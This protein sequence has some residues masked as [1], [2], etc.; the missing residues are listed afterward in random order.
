MNNNTQR[1][2]LTALFAA[3]TCVATLVIR[4]PTPG[5]SGYIHPGDALVILSGLLLGPGPGF[6]AAG[7]GA[8]LADLIGGY[9]LYVP[10]TFLIKGIIAALCG[11]IIR[12]TP[13][14]TK[15]RTLAVVLG[16]LVDTLLVAG[17]YLLYEYTLYGAGAIA[18]VPANIIQGIG[19]LVIALILSPALSVL[20]SAGKWT[21]D[22][23]H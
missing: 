13:D 14:T 18:S 17:G 15:G 16:G 3:L 20:P 19:G 4:I 6:L 11:L 8:G 7:L 22:R 5:T 21:N 1:L 10:A 12:R 2:V 9:T 23:R